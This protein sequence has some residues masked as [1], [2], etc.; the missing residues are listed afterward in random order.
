MP[1]A[2]CAAVEQGEALRF[3]VTD[4]GA[5]N[6]T[7]RFMLRGD[8]GEIPCLPGNATACGFSATLAET[9]SYILGIYADGEQVAGGGM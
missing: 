4:P 9:G 6:V 8:G 1:A 3:E 5:R 2:Q 7:C